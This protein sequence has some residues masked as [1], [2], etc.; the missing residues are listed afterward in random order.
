MS[1]PLPLTRT[2]AYLAYKAGVIQQSELKPS[3]SVPRI[4]IDAWLAYWTGLKDEYPKNPDGT[5]KMLQEEEKYI[6]YLCGVTDKYPEKCL[7]RVGAY[8]RYLISARWGRP[9]HPLNREELYLSLIKTQF[10]PSGDPSSDITIDGTAKAAFVDVKVY[11]D[12]FQQ[13]YTG[14]NLVGFPTAHLTNQDGLTLDFAEDGTITIDGTRGST[15]AAN[16]NDSTLFNIPAGSFTLTVIPIS[17]S[18][19]GVRIGTRAHKTNIGHQSWYQAYNSEGQYSQG[20][21]TK[22]AEEIAKVAGI[23]LLIGSGTA[24]FNNFKF[25]IQ[26]TAGSDHDTNY[27]PYVG[28]TPSP[29]PDYP[30]PIQTVTELQTV[31]IRG[32]NLFN[33]Q[34]Y[35][36]S[37]NGAYIVVEGTSVTF[38][39]NSSG[40]SG[41]S[42]RTQEEPLSLASGNTIVFSRTWLNGNVWERGYFYINLTLNYSDGTSETIQIPVTTISNYKTEMSISKTLE[43]DVVSLYLSGSSYEVIGLMEP[44]TF[45]VQLEFGSTATSYESYSSND[46]EINLGKNLF[47]K[48]IGILSGY[49][50]AT[51]GN[52]IPLS[53]ASVQETYIPVYPNTPYVMSTEAKADQSSDFRVFICEYDSNKAFIKRNRPNPVTS[54]QNK[55]V[56]TADTRFVRLCFSNVAKDTLQFEAGTDATPYAPYFEPIELC[57]LG[58]YQDYIWKDKDQW[59]LHK[60]TGSYTFNG[61]EPNWFKSGNTTDTIL[62]AAISS[63]FKNILDMKTSER[64]LIKSDYFIWRNPLN[65]IIGSIDVYNGGD[66]MGMSFDIQK[67]PNLASAKAW[68]AANRPT[69]L[70]VLATPTDTVITNQALIDQLEA[71]VKGGSEDGTTYIKVSAAEPNLPAKLY[72]EAPKF[73][74]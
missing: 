68:V 26:V 22:T 63:G 17:G 24:V 27:E 73:V 14:K 69:I 3:L 44:I 9:D 13:T 54:S 6:A 67:I 28:G 58:N 61:E 41:M 60:E 46:Y 37:W 21:L 12:T 20:T 5:P 32:K 38:I 39:A 70:V 53:G 35:H 49:T 29:N 64:S 62:V 71:L 72:V 45:G 59:K 34:R 2:E 52:L 57:K 43:K 56:T 74:E 33:F 1:Y 10:I 51:N 30:Q 11:G 4:G 18:F 36:N 16:Y 31:E 42:F 55:I 8:L 7:R 15:S 47:D 48:N 40:A 23:Q 66:S 65:Q 25:K 50:Y 19:E